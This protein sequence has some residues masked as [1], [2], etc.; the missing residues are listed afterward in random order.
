MTRPGIALLGLFIWTASLSAQQAAPPSSDM[1]QLQQEIKQLTS[2]LQSMRSEVQACRDEIHSLRSELEAAKSAQSAEPG[3]EADVTHAVADLRED[4]S[5]TD[6]RVATLYQTKVESGSNYRLRLSGLALFNTFVNRGTVNTTSVPNLALPTPEGQPGGSIGGTFRQTFFTLQAFGPEIAGARTSA[7]VQ[8]GFY[9]G[10]TRTLDGYVQ[11]LASLRTADIAFD[12]SKWSLNFTQDKPFISPLSPTSLAA[13]GTPEFAYSGDLWTWTPQIVAE[14]TWEVS[15][16]VKSHVQFGVLDPFDGEVPAGYYLRQPE[17]GEL[18][19]T[20]AI[21]ARPSLDFPIGSQVATI[22][23][24]GYFARQNYGYGHVVDAWA[25]TLD[26]NLP[27]GERWALSGE[28]HRGL[29]L[30]GMW[31]AI[32]TSVV[33]IAPETNPYASVVGVNTV[34]G[35]SQL[36]FK[37]AEK[38]EVNGAFGEESPFAADLLQNADPTYQPVLRNWT[39]MVN[40]IDHPRSN[41]LL[42]LEYRHLNTVLF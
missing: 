9:G 12:W 40:V 30:G 26:W 24:G 2:S 29:G 27:F 19:R 13:I 6:S 8:F 11:G 14:R 33:Y 3:T 17:A 37:P 35:W 22:G 36:K 1:Q 42:S 25:A 7:E 4:Q 32:G 20:P 28:L 23:A 10:F 38:W 31:G 16:R 21:A 39:T 15:D 5:V 41:L 18:S 34:G